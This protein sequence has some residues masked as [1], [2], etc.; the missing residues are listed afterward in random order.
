MGAVLFAASLWPT[1]FIVSASYELRIGPAAAADAGIDDVDDCTVLAPPPLGRVLVEALFELFA[2][3][4]LLLLPPP[5]NLK[6]PP[7]FC[8]LSSL[9]L[10]PSLEGTLESGRSVSGS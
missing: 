4:L 7:P 9:S 6:P 8:G 5:K 3:L 2:L 1:L 10:E